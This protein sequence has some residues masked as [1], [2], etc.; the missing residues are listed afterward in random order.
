MVD[1]CTGKISWGGHAPDECL[2]CVPG[3]D[4]EEQSVT[5]YR[6]FNRNLRLLYVGIAGNPGR[7]FSQHASDKFWWGEVVDVRLIHYP[8]REEARVAEIQ[9][10]R[11]ENPLYNIADRAR[12]RA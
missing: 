1:V 3:D 10:I 2:D 11:S 6:L 8:T 5:L 9:A 12:G 4:D 7:R